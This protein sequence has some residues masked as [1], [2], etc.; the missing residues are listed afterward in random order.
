MSNWLYSMG[1]PLRVSGQQLDSKRKVRQTDK[2]TNTQ[3]D[4]QALA[5]S[6]TAD[7]NISPLA[8]SSYLD[9]DNQQRLQ[10]YQASHIMSSP[11]FTLPMSTKFA[12]A[13]Q[14]FKQKEFRH[15][16]VVDK[17]Q[18]VVGILSDRDMLKLSGSSNVNGRINHQTI[19]KLMV[20][21]VLMASPTT[22]IQ[23]ICQAMFSRRI[24]A[25]PIV[26]NSDRLL[27]IITRSDILHAMIKHGPLELW[28]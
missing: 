19:G 14:L 26:D 9:K 10:V 15:V 28:I 13:W 27:G 7:E 18:K 25:L 3:L 1:M 22:R 2:Q 20:T 24:G 11:V 12:Q 16:I 21:P 5:G 8:L 23:D 6:N 4:D 17:N